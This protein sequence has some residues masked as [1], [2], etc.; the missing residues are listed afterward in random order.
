MKSPG[1]LDVS[2]GIGAGLNHPAMFTGLAVLG[3]V[4]LNANEDTLDARSIDTTGSALDWFTIIEDGLPI[5]SDG[6]EYGDT[7]GWS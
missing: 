4:I 6:F 2:G 7:G 3:S 1:F 5:F